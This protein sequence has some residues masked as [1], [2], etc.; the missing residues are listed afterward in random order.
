MDVGDPDHEPDHDEK[1]NDE[2]EDRDHVALTLATEMALPGRGGL[3]DAVG[4]GFV[5]G[6]PHQRLGALG[7]CITVGLEQIAETATLIG[8]QALLL[9]ELATT[10]LKR[11]RVIAFSRHAA[12][13]SS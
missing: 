5:V 13:A 2:A 8:K 1:K 10:G 6:P 9:L 4:G 7:L 3:D 11:V 12:E